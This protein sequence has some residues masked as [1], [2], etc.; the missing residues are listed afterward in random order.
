MGVVDM[1]N[2]NPPS[3][4]TKDF[5]ASPALS[6]SLAGIFRD[7]GAAAASRA[8]S[9]G[10]GGTEVEEGDE[11]S[12]GGGGARGLGLREETVEISSENSGPARSRSDDEFDPDGDPDDD[13]DGDKKKKKRKKYHRHTAEQI[14]EMESLFKES[15]HPDEKQRQQLS[16]QLG[17][18]PRQV[19]FWFQNRR[20]QLK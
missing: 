2:N 14:R 20:T 1:S 19:K 4:R 15:P 6:L 8:E 7:A 17:L 10:G 9:G 12:G 11:G 13:N 3:S 16:K 5:F 18:A